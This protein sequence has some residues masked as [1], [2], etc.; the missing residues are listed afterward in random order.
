MDQDDRGIVVGS[1]MAVVSTTDEWDRIV[2]DPS[3]VG[4]ADPHGNPWRFAAPVLC[5]S[6]PTALRGRRRLTDGETK[7]IVT[8][9]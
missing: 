8:E 3:G 1:L 2:T 6:E 9:T 5:R 4:Q 7:G